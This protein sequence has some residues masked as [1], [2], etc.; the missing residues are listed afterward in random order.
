SKRWLE[1]GKTTSFPIPKDAWDRATDSI[2]KHIASIRADML[3]VGLTAG[4][5]QAL[6]TEFQLLEAAHQ[7]D[8]SVTDAQI[9]K[10]T[11]LRG[12]MSAQQALDA[13]GIQ[14]SAERRKEFEK[15][16]VTIEAVANRYALLKVQSDAA[17]E[18]S[19]LG[20]G[21]ID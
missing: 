18:R 13:A 3:A 7:A 11:E 9:K 20:R 17:F 15:D 12:V 14:L 6:R 19:Q 16:I 10:Y 1:G 2:N 5:H 21:T 4:A 8:N